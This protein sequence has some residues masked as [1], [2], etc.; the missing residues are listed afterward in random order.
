MI[1]F[2]IILDRDNKYNIRK[3]ICLFYATTSFIKKEPL[4]PKGRK[5]YVVPPQFIQHKNSSILV[6]DL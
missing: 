3:A 6:S 2:H 4:H 5:D 1:E